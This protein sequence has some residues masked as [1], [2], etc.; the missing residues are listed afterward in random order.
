MQNVVMAT[1]EY[2]HFGGGGDGGGGAAS[3]RNAPCARGTR[4]FKFRHI[5]GS[6]GELVVHLFVSLGKIG[7][8]SC[9]FVKT[10]TRTLVCLAPPTSLQRWHTLAP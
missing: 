3:R 8:F 5:C 4:A 2:S 1:V 10:D 7:L 6:E 9:M